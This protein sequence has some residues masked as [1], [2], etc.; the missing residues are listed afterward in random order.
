MTAQEQLSNPPAR[1]SEAAL[2]KK[3]ED[4]GIGRPSTYAPT[5]NT[6]QQRGYVE[7][8]SSLGIPQAFAI[9]TLR[10]SKVTWKSKSKAVG[11]YK[12]RLVPTDIGILVTDFLHANFANIM[13]YQFTANV[14][15]Q[16]DIIATGKLRWQ[17][18]IEDF[19]TPF[20]VTVDEVMETAE[21][22]HGERVI[23]TDPVS[24]KVVKVRLGKFGPMVQIGESDDP[25][26]K[27]AALRGD[28][29]LEHI[30]LADALELFKFPK[31]IGEREGSP[32][33]VNT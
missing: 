22:A 7:K 10:A 33:K 29:R 4:L 26:K 19:Y 5:I 8:N 18:M 21:R 24:G 27:F 16:F 2:V 32:L 12:N 6:I 13:D 17:R 25:D 23:G 31:V 20:H 15:A 14:E 30:Q 11:A 3:L 9:A 28:N 1:Y